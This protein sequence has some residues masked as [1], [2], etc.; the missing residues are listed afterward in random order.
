[1]SVDL[2]ADVL[3]SDRLSA[4]RCASTYGQGTSRTIIRAARRAYAEG[5]THILPLRLTL[6]LRDI[7]ESL[8]PLLQAAAQHPESVILGH[9]PAA[10]FKAAR[11]WRRVWFRIQTGQQLTDS[12][13]DAQVYP[14]LLFEH[15]RLWH[16]EFTLPNELLVKAAWAGVS[17]HEV[18]LDPSAEPLRLRMRLGR[19]VRCE[20]QLALLNFVLTLRAVWPWP[21]KRVP[22]LSAYA[23]PVSLRHPLQSLRHLRRQNMSPRQLAAAGALGVFLGALPLFALHTVTI[24]FS[25]GYLGLNRMVALSTSQLC[26]PPL[27]PALCISLGYYLRHGRFLTELSVQTLGYQAH[28]RLLEWLLGS[29]L[30]AP[31]LAVGIGGLIYGS[32]WMVFRNMPDAKPGPDG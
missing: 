2:P 19:R 14:L 10:G 13:S 31:L 6:V 26:M 23:D 25:A 27:V 17:I 24:L 16:R 11:L 5:F 12:Q 29:L 7:S 30:L 32:A 20:V 28:E 21:H 1:M 3:S 8:Q 9:R 22:G 4:V 18:T 15:L